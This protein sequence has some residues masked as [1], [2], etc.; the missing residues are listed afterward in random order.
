MSVKAAIAIAEATQRRG[1]YLTSEFMA[2]QIIAPPGYAGGSDNLLKTDFPGSNDLVHSITLGETTVFN[3]SVVN[4]VHFAVNKAKVDN[5]QT[6]F[7]SPRDIGANIYSYLPGYMSLTITGGFRLYT[8]TNTKALFLNDTYQV[9]DDLTMV[10]GTH[11][12][13]IGGNL[14]YWT[15]DYTSTS[16]ANGNWIFDGSTTGLGL[17]DFLTGRL[18]SVEHACHRDA[19]RGRTDGTVAQPAIR[20]RG[21]RSDRQH[22]EG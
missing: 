20:V 16:R 4:A 11:Q 6:P 10:K 5:Y 1:I 19:R 7:F 9:A 21:L 22:Q 8:G 17:A 15:G 18:T 14:Q 2:T 3:A 12:F 13:G